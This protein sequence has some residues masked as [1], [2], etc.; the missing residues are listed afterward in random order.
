MTYFSLSALI[1]ALVSWLLGFYILGKNTKSKVNRAFFFWCSSVAIWSSFYFLWQISIDEYR[2]LL[3]SRLLMFGAVWV[4]V[5]FYHFATIFLGIEK[6][7]KKIIIFSYLLGTI[8]TILLFTRL[9]V[10]HVEANLAGFLFWPRPGIAYIFFLIMFA[11]FTAYPVFLAHKALKDADSIK[12]QQI[13]YILIGIIIAI[14]G[15]STNY[16][17]WYDI[18]I[19]PYGNILVL[20]YPLLTAYAIIRYRFADIRLI[21]KRSAVF[22][23]IVL[24]ITAIYSVLAYLISILFTDLIG[25]QSVFLNGILTAV[26]VALGFEPLKKSLSVATDKYLF[27]AP[28]NP[29]EVLGEFSEKLT[30]TLDLKQIS[31]F[32][33]KRTGEVFKPFFVSL[34]LLKEEKKEYEKEIVWGKTSDDL[35]K[36]DSKIFNKVFNYLQSI[37]KEKEILV[38]EE[39]KKINEQLDNPVLKLLIEM[40]EKYAVNLIVPLYVRD[41]LTGILFLGDKK[42]G[43]IYSSEDIRMLE[44]ISGQSAVAIQNAKLFEEQKK[45]ASRLKREVDKAT[46]EL[47]EAN[48][49]LKKLDRAKSEF[50]SIASH[51]LRTPLTVIKGY[52]SMI[53]QGDFG[54]VPGK[55]AEPLDRVYKSTLRI[56][57]LVEDLLNIS[58]IESGRMKYSFE[59]ADLLE[60]IEDVYEEL[61]QHAENKGLKFVLQKPRVKIPLIIFDKAKV[62]EVVMNLMDNAIKYTD[63]G[64]VNVE[65]KRLNNTLEFCVSDSGRGLAPDEMPMLFQKFSRAKGVQLVH[66]EGTGLGLYIAKNILQ[67]H[68]A[69]IWAESEGRNKGSKFCISFKIENKKLEKKLGKK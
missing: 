33:T 65:L 24:I 41:K 39:I 61:K 34:F 60:V 36:I 23:L 28:Y 49:Q 16:L 8:F 54:Q 22:T 43:D 9:M 20:A 48:V 15:G 3:F 53:N 35:P 14:A 58:R 1:N 13:K 21:I 62:R 51:Q 17:L 46:K 44:I 50:I 18:P 37:N 64:F 11:S 45:F 69:K 26:F 10:S 66:T 67:K 29:Q 56:I 2:A 57:G 7:E 32:I 4:P 42:S 30:S 6:K 19:K 40:L 31:N 47:K 68:Q 55:V 38:K 63:K 52:I 5:T 27:K 12:K 59:K 25:V